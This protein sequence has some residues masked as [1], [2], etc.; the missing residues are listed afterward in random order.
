MA[1]IISKIDTILQIPANFKNLTGKE[2]LTIKLIA[3]EPKEVPDNILAHYTK[4]RPHVFRKEGEPE[5]EKPQGGNIEDLPLAFDPIEF[6]TNNYENIESGL[7]TLEDPIRPKLF[8]L[9]QALKLSGYNTQKNERMK[10]RIVVDIKTKIEQ[11]K[12][13]G[14]EAKNEN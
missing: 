4:H 2:P 13:I 9:C 1:K 14:E 12:K 11:S 7:E 3:E 5:L 6:I 10:E 8:A